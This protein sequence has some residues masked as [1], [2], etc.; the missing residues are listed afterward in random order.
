[1]NVIFGTT[2]LLIHPDNPSISV[3]WQAAK[4]ANLCTAA[5]QTQGKVTLH[6]S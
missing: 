5:F 3:E 6:K 1:M 4:T 2:A